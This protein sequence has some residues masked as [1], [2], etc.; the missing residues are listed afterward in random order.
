MK[1]S[2]TTSSLLL[3]VAICVLYSGSV[4]AFLEKDAQPFSLTAREYKNP[5]PGQISIIASSPIPHGLKPTRE[6]YEQ[7]IECGFNVGCE[8]G[9]IEYYK[10]VF[11]MLDTL[12]FKYLIANGELLTD[13]CESF[14]SAL[15]GDPHLAGW[16]FKDEPAFSI[17]PELQEQYERLCRI[18]TTNLIYM[19]LIGAQM[20][21]NTGNTKDYF[22]YLKLIQKMFRP[23]VWSYDCYPFNIKR[24]KLNISYDLFYSDLE[25]IS[26]ISKD[27]G[28]P[29]WAFCQ[30][31]AFKTKSGFE[32]PAATAA[33]LRFEAFSALAY[34]AQGIVYW[35]YGQRKSSE[36]TDF[37]SALV[38][39]DGEKTKAWY[40]AKKVNA[41]IRRFNDVFYDC[42]VI[43]VCH[44]GKQRYRDTR[45]LS[46]S[47]GP[48]SK[49]NS[50]DAGILASYIK[51]GE[52][53]YVVIV[54]HEVENSQEVAFKLSPKNSVRL[55]SRDR[56]LFFDKGKNFKIEIE[57]GGYLI[58]RIIK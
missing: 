38:N 51:N 32:R 30:S 14:V 53:E 17:L 44:T 40:D 26:K 28:R 7:L 58:F 5:S 18:D 9:S 27:T 29:F 24:D 35:T 39:S 15:S 43:K 52:E 10:G 2:F 56:E 31:M 12:D 11:E 8:Y 6:A 34:G 13:K 20:E 1:P 57:K 54:N 23:Q 42:N 19:N 46:G 47:F 16:Y 25:N 37:L 33:Y 36:S 4:N 55:I 45:M 49:I 22:S 41:E 50:G 48:F 3:I 21:V